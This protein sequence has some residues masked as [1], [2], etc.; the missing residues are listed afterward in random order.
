MSTFPPSSQKKRPAR[1]K[2]AVKIAILLLNCAVAS[3]FA[4]CGNLIIPQLTFRLGGNN[5]EWPCQSTKNIYTTTGRYIP[6]HIIPTRAQ[7]Y[8]D[9]AFIAM[10]RYKSGVPITLGRA[11]LKKGHC[12][13]PVAPFP[14]WSLQE[15]GNCQALQ[16]VADIFLDSQVGSEGNANDEWAHEVLKMMEEWPNKNWTRNAL[17]RFKSSLST[18]LGVF[19]ESLVDERVSEAFFNFYSFFPFRTS[20]GP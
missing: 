14:C 4:S 10:P 1:L 20:S 11:S 3:V 6:R 17:K 16:S 2:M 8:H 7:I 12:S 5:L 9:E 19:L 15:E 13:V 18:F